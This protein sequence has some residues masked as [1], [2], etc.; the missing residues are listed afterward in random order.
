M[1]EAQ[2]RTLDGLLDLRQEIYSPSVGAGGVEVT[3]ACRSADPGCQRT[4]CA[5]CWDRTMDIASEER[6]PEGDCITRREQSDSVREKQRP[7]GH[8]GRKTGVSKAASVDFV[9]RGGSWPKATPLPCLQGGGLG[10]WLC[11]LDFRASVPIIETD[12]CINLHFLPREGG[13]GPGRPGWRWA[14]QPPGRRH[15][16]V[17]RRSVPPA[18]LT[19]VKRWM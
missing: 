14:P 10:R 13:I 11:D 19:I 2:A 7:D 6:V 16:Q 1:Q 17:T 15:D 12:H 9:P 18:G 3:G 4:V 5:V 8:R